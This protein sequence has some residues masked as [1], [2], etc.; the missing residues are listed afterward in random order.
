MPFSK[1]KVK[2]SDF[3]LQSFKDY[4]LNSKGFTLIELM[5]AL[6]IV[7]VVFGV[8]ITTSAG[9]QRQ[10]RDSQRK[11]DLSKIQTALQQYYTDE[12]KYP[13]ST[14]LGLSATALKSLDNTKTYL[15][16]IP[17]DPKGGAYYYMPVLNTAAS[18]TIT[19]NLCDGSGGNSSNVC[20]YYY[21][22]AKL[23]TSLTGTCVS[24]SNSNFQLNP[25]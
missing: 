18:P 11:A 3:S 17:R 22:C 9:I 13:P 8:V 20:H 16:G 6:A 25:F 10:S 5:V 19:T 1:L 23:E 24:D 2:I 21:L 4:I 15:N 7:A 12:N 14:A